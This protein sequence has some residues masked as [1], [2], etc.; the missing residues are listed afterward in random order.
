[1]A[2]AWHLPMA[3]HDCSGPVVLT[4]ATHLSLSMPNALFQESVRAFHRTWYR[5]LVTALPE[6][7]G[8]MITVPPGAGLGLALSPDMARDFTVV[9]EISDESSL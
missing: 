1:M 9:R 7:R 4:A 5:H 2:E 8:G 3:P 6:I